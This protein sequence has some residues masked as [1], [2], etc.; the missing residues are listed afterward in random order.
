MSLMAKRRIVV[1]RK[2]KDDNSIA[3]LRANDFLTRFVTRS[4][5]QIPK[6]NK[7]SPALQKCFTSFFF[8]FCL[9]QAD[10]SRRENVY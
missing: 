9:V 2:S 1:F 4:E 8:G 5:Q 7:A 3:A 10:F 6:R